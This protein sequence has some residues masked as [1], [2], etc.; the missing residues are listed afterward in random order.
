MV[1]GAV[2]GGPESPGVQAPR[3]PAPISS[4]SPR[5]PFGGPRSLTSRILFSTY[6]PTYLPVHPRTP[7]GKARDSTWKFGVPPSPHGLNPGSCGGRDRHE[8]ASPKGPRRAGWDPDVWGGGGHAPTSL[9][10]RTAHDPAGQDGTQA[11]G[12]G[13]TPETRPGLGECVGGAE[14]GPR[15]P[16]VNGPPP[17]PQ[18]PKKAK[19]RTAD[20]GSNVFSMFD[21][22]Q[23]QEFKEVRGGWGQDW[24]P[25]PWLG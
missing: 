2:G 10:Q 3:P 18:A 17:S 24:A 22:T 11:S 23:I 12:R 21:Q 14:T 9:P 4:S 16:E 20:G 7:P 5:S 15:S 1:S 19:K 6:L 13:G 25:F 8:A